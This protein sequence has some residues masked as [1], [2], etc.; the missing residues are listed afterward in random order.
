MSANKY[1]GKDFRVKLE[2]LFNKNQR[3]AVATKYS[4]GRAGEYTDMNSYTA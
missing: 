1:S 2:K 4:Q 3:A